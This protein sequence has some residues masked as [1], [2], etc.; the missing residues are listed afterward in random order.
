MET[1]R[2]NLKVDNVFNTPLPQDIEE[3]G[4]FIPTTSILKAIGTVVGKD[5]QIE[6]AKGCELRGDSTD[7]FAEAVRIA[8]AADVAI[9]VVGEKGGLTDDSTSGE[10][11]DRA[12][13]NLTGMQSELVRAVYETGTPV[14]VVLANGRPISLGWIADKV[15]A[16]IEAWFPSEEG[17]NAITDVLFGDVNPGGKLPMTFPRAV[18]QVP[19][20][21]AHKPS[22]GRSHWKT[23][24][25]EMPVTPQYA[26]GHGLSY[27]QFEYGN[28]RINADNARA[29]GEVTV[30]LAV[31]NSGDRAGDEVVQVYTHQFV[32]RVTR[33]VQELKAFKRI[34]LE[35]G[36]TATLTFTLPINQLGFYDLEHH[37]V[38]Q[39]G[40]VDIM[41]GSSSQDIRCSGSFEISGQVMDVGA[42]KAF[43]S[44]VHVDTVNNVRTPTS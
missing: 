3:A 35:P 32:P 30:Q 6:Y 19:V 44:S 37:Y 14:V 1:L 22:G 40:T 12:D 5:T 43:F 2:E 16:I 17:A 26:F 21:Y 38:V 33:P 42:H 27:T 28:L 23:D 13:L 4:D 34:T 9:V 31:T 7:G 29:G 15:P 11:R 25:V 10:A 24:Y 41:V 18:G 39:P 20:F 8:K 36:E